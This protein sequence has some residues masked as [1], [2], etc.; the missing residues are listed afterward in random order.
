MSTGDARVGGALVPWSSAHDRVGVFPL[1]QVRK[2]DW[3]KY[4][5]LVGK[6]SNMAKEDQV[7]HAA[8]RTPPPLRGP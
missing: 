4:R 8:P 5:K 1:S 2:L 6:K 7:L 3:K